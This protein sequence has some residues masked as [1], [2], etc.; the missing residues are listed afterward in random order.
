LLNENSLGSISSMVKPDT[1]QAKRSEKVSRS[2]VSFFDLLALSAE[3]SARA[4]GRSANS[5]MAS[6]SASLSAVSSESAS[7]LP[8]S[9][10]TTSRS[11]TT[12]M[13]CLNFLP[14][15]GTDSIS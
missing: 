13:S 14:S 1:G 8:R 6:P 12:S 11:T 10:L 7:R 5:A 9:R 3:V 4:S 15:A 2:C